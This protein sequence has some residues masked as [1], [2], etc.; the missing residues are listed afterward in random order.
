[1]YKVK[2]GDIN[3]TTRNKKVRVEIGSTKKPRLLLLG[4]AGFMVVVALAVVVVSGL[5]N[6]S[7]KNP[8]KYKTNGHGQ[9]KTLKI[10]AVDSP[11]SFNGL[12]PRPTKAGPGQKLLAITVDF[13]RDFKNQIRSSETGEVYLTDDT[14]KTNFYTVDT[15]VP[16]GEGPGKKPTR[17]ATFVFSVPQSSGALTLHYGTLYSIALPAR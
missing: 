15:S 1:M 17:Q 2:R 12:N 7:A 10:V 5:S 6:V 13:D 4:L 11:A 8:D 9:T 14:L 16:V 3:M